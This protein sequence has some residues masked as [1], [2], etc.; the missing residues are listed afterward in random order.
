VPWVHTDRMGSACFFEGEGEARFPE[1]GFNINVLQPGEVGGMY[2]AE[3]AQEGFLVLS[4]DG[5]AVV[6]DE[7]RPLRQWDY[8][9]CPAR[10][11]HILVG[12]G[13]RPLV[14]VAVGTRPEGRSLEY[15]ANDT[16]RK[17]G[18]SVEETTSAPKEA[19]AGHE[20]SRGSYREGDL[21]QLG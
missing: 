15:P 3:G 20:F 11:P 1:L 19:Y 21:P 16:A 2:H 18:A 8:F 5:L 10:T 17:H 9:H 7:E 6:E 12:I 13:D 4:G 14:Y